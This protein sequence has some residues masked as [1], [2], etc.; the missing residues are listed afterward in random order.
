[1]FRKITRAWIISPLPRAGEGEG[2]GKI[3]KHH[4]DLYPLPPEEGEE[5]FESEHI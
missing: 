5:V 2:E 3:L 4:P 1:V